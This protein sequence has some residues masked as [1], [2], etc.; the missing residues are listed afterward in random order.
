MIEVTRTEIP[1]LVLL[2]PKVHGDA[3]GY[4]ME[5]FSERELRQAGLPSLFIQ[6]NES[7]SC[8]GTIRGLHFQV[9]P[10]AQTKLVRVLRGLILDVA[11]DL[12]KDS[13]TFGRAY[14]VQLS[15]DNR[16]QILVPRGFA[17]G[18]AVLSPEAVVCYKV[19]S[20]YSPEHEKGLAYNDP[21]LAIDWQVPVEKI[22]LS[23]RDR[24]HP[25]LKE[26]L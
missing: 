26:L 19:D 16:T 25:T 6:D 10:H 2:Q 4:F 17:H 18:F 9:T 22:I 20:F 21:E 12:R 11:V 13:P 7:L 5:T 24:H 23:D 1:D 3:R 15:G 8:Y 14:S